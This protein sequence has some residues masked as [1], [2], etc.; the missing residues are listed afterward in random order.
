MDFTDYGNYIWMEWLTY[1]SVQEDTW[2]F[3]IY[4]YWNIVDYIVLVSGI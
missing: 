3:K 2:F 4:L 1:M